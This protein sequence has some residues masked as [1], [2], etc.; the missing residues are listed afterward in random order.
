MS[1]QKA[2]LIK[3]KLSSSYEKAKELKIYEETLRDFIH[4][5]D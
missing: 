1:N 4:E 2:K 5:R 3:I